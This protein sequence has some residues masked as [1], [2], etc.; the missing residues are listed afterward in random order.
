MI[1]KK[2]ITHFPD[3]DEYAVLEDEI[4]GWPSI[5]GIR[6]LELAE[7]QMPDWEVPKVRNIPPCCVGC[8]NHPDNGGTGICLCTL[9]YMN[10]TADP[11]SWFSWDGTK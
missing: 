2:D 11:S 5:H 10:Q 8:N 3:S 7:F 1:L 4:V 6:E 9:P